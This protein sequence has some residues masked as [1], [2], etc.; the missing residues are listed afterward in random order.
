[1][2]QQI[3][4]SNL[5]IVLTMSE[6]RMKKNNHDLMFLK[7]NPELITLNLF[8]VNVSAAKT[9]AQ[10][11]S[12]AK[13][14]D[15]SVVRAIH[16]ASDG[17]PLLI[18]Q[19]VRHFHDMKLLT[20][21][22]HNKDEMETILF[23][24]KDFENTRQQAAKI[25][26][27]RAKTLSPVDVMVLCI[28]SVFN[29]LTVSSS[30]ILAYQWDQISLPQYSK[31]EALDKDAVLEALQSLN[32]RGFISKIDKQDLIDQ[33][34]GDMFHVPSMRRQPMGAPLEVKEEDGREE[35]E[36]GGESK[37]GGGG[38][39]FAGEANTRFVIRKET[40]HRMIL[41]YN[42]AQI[43]TTHHKLG[44][45]MEIFY[46][47]D[48]HNHYVELAYHFQQGNNL[49]KAQKLLLMAG[50]DAVHMC[51]PQEAIILFMEA[52]ELMQEPGGGA[53]RGGDGAAINATVLKVGDDDDTAE[54]GRSKAKD[55]KVRR[56][57]KEAKSA[58]VLIYYYTSPPN[59]NPQ[60]AQ[61][62]RATFFSVKGKDK[63]HEIGHIHRM[64]GEAFYY[65]GDFS[66][67]QLHLEKALKNFGPGPNA[68]M[69]RGSVTSSDLRMRAYTAFKF[70]KI[71]LTEMTHTGLIRRSTKELEPVVRALAME[72]CEAWFRLTQIHYFMGN[73]TSYAYCALQNYASAEALGTS[74][75]L[76]LAVTQFI[77]IFSSLG[78]KVWAEFYCRESMQMCEQVDSQVATA[79]G[80]LSRAIYMA[81]DGQI[82][83]AT[84]MHMMA[85]QM[86]EMAGN[87]QAWCECL[88]MMCTNH[89]ALGNYFDVL[90][91]TEVGISS[92]L[93]VDNYT[94]IQWFLEAKISALLCLGRQPEAMEVIS[95]GV[96]GGFAR[97]YKGDGHEGHYGGTPIGSDENFFLPEFARACMHDGKG[98]KAVR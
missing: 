92:S 50:D 6:S 61:S 44:T 43:A 81:G 62:A 24:L 10:V 53:G 65:I 86:F 31:I 36:S 22:T 77:P 39:V 38:G 63:S 12:H 56:K 15:S 83:A 87:V 28:M 30:E 21:N 75:E 85:S 68:S 80:L 13:N 97:N 35:S 20:P 95:E 45:Q 49:H 55:K 41:E 4:T 32:A 9:M 33:G 5:F 94:M 14:V 27:L 57:R 72:R 19:I 1:V 7:A 23:D 70:I 73:K 78:Q 69:F 51:A 47:N 46:R 42:D 26:A 82:I 58:R 93:K 96:A 71:R 52:L 29:E 64:M 88:A 67:S 18:E 59:P 91:F 3:C 90:T 34:I 54:S 16:K 11:L 25:A 84:E 8:P 89:H 48:L 60:L 2:V 66:N 79:F 74:A 98:D 17:I 40:V 76:C 37:A